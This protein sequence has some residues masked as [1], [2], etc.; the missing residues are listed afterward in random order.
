MDAVSFL[1]AVKVAAKRAKT[2]IQGAI[3]TTINSSSTN[4]KAAGAKAVYNYCGK[5][6][7][8][9]DENSTDAQF[10]TAK[11]VYDAIRAAIQEQN[12]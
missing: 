2:A 7:T 12:E 1:L 6:V 11:A 3:A 8:V 4:T 9:I 5:K 10:P